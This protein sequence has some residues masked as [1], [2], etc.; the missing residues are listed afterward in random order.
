MPNSTN[1]AHAMKWVRRAALLVGIFVFGIFNRFPAVGAEVGPATKTSTVHGLTSISIRDV[2]NTVNV[3][4]TLPTCLRKVA[5][6]IKPI[7]IVGCGEFLDSATQANTDGMFSQCRSARRTL[8]TNRVGEFC[9]YL[10]NVSVSPTDIEVI[11]QNAVSFTISI[12]PSESVNN[13]FGTVF[14]NKLLISDSRR[15]PRIIPK[16]SSRNGKNCREDGCPHRGIVPPRAIFT[17][18]AIG[19][20][21]GFLILWFLIWLGR[22]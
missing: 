13:Y 7:S 21:L 1:W 16:A 3:C 4:S 22:C 5:A 10:K 6:E 12:I 2:T 9:G 20:C 8:H 19:C 11:E 18:V 17:G 14:R 15:S